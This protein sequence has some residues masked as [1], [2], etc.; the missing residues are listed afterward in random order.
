MSFDTVR[1]SFDAVRRSFGARSARFDANVELCRPECRIALNK[2]RIV[3]N[4]RWISVERY[5]ISFDTIQRSVW[6]D[7][8]NVQP[9]RRSKRRIAPNGRRMALNSVEHGDPR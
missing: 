2:H 1:R 7:G 3:P 4:K 9:V 6:F 8:N 5:L